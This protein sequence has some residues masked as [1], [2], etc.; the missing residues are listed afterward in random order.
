MRWQT[1]SKKTEYTDMVDFRTPRYIFKYLNTIEKIEYDGACQDG[2][3]NLATSLR[4]EDEWPEGCVYSNPP[5]DNDSIIKWVKKGY[6]HSRKS[7]K[8]TH[9]MLIPN[10]LTQVKIQEHCSNK[11]DSLIFLGG[12]VDFDSIYSVK[13]GSSRMG[14]VILIQKIGESGFKFQPLKKIKELFS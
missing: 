12:R 7:E 6:I 13:G 8:N 3:N 14:S 5:F 1:M 9:I 4:L 10:K 11:I 2:I